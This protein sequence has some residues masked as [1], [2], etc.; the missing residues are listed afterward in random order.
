MFAA[1]RCVVSMLT[2]ELTELERGFANFKRLVEAD[3][4]L[5][6]PRRHLDGTNGGGGGVGLAEHKPM[7]WLGPVRREEGVGR[8]GEGQRQRGGVLL[9]IHRWCCSRVGA[10]YSSSSLL[11]MRANAGA[12]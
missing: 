1:S 7:R 11:C 3:P 6:S 9:I 10:C 5:R 8:T 2:S 4:S 12:K